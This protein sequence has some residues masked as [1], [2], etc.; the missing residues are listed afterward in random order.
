MQTFITVDGN[1]AA[2]NIAYKFSDM[3]IVYPITPS[4]P[5]AEN[6]DKW[7]A[8]NKTNLWGNKVRLTQ[9]QSEAGAAA[10]MHGALN[11]GSLATTFTGFYLCYQICIKWRANATLRLFMLPL[12]P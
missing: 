8:D 10:A 7:Q 9:M 11:A 4:S 5:M 12:E 6:V 2:S 3:A 1:T